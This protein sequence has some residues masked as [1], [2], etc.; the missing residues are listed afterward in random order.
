MPHPKLTASDWWAQ[1]ERDARAAQH[2]LQGGFEVQAVALAHLSV[3][4][5]LKSALRAE[6]GASPPVTHNLTVLAERISPVLPPDLADILDDLSGLDISLLYQPE[7]LFR[8][9]LPNS[10]S[11]ARRVVAHAQSIR[12]WLRQQSATD[13]SESE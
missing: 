8:R 7:A 2:L 1:S 6:S 12:D 11:E 5:A 4:K 13:L 10:M 3:E 9:Q